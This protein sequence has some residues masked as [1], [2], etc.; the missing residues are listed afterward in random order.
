VLALQRVAGNRAVAGLLARKPAVAAAPIWTG[1][2]FLPGEENLGRM[3]ALEGASIVERRGK[4]KRTV[5]TIAADGRYTLVDE[6]GNAIAGTGGSVGELVG[7]V[8]KHGDAAA[9]RVSATTGTGEFSLADESGEHTFKIKDGGVYLVSGKRQELVGEV[10]AGGRYQLKLGEHVRSGSLTDLG[11]GKVKGSFKLTHGK[12]VVGQLQIGQDPVPEGLLLLPEGKH[13]VKDGAL[14]RS[15]SKTAVGQVRIARSGPKLEHLSLRATYSD[16]AGKLHDYDLT[17]AVPGAGSAL[18]L[19]KGRSW[20][21]STGARWV[22]MSAAHTRK[23]LEMFGGGRVKP[24]LQALRAAGKLALTDDEIDLMQA[25][26]EVESSGYLQCINTWDSDEVSLGFIQYT[27]AGSL[28]EL[29]EMAPDAFAR[30]GIRLGGQTTLKRPGLGDVTVKGIQGVSDPQELRSLEWATKFFLAGLDDEIIVAEAT[31]AR[32]DIAATQAK[33]L[34]SSSAAP[35]LNSARVVAILLE[36][37]NN[38]PAYV[39]PV[40]KRTA[41]RIK[42]KPQLTVAEVVDVLQ[43][44]MEAEYVKYREK[45]GNGATDEEARQKARNIVTKTAA[46]F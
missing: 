12:Q 34:G 35:Q 17:A 43:E 21:V 39:S 10:D 41:A 32:A 23:G 27:L 20:I 30:Y 9:G 40:V 37:N 4:N 19:G 1:T 13:L 36:L 11:P 7:Q 8:N 28:Q 24:K 16:D 29:I 31:K 38:R 5:G 45:H 2:V 42:D 33:L 15:G 18:R 6:E 22:E 14:Y 25:T 44:E 46:A 26:A 3:F